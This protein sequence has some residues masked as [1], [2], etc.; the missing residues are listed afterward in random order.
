MIKKGVKLKN[1]VW[2]KP[3]IKK[4]KLLSTL[5]GLVSDTIKSNYISAFDGLVNAIDCFDFSKNNEQLGWILISKSI[6]NALLELIVENKQ[7]IEN[8]DFIVSEDFEKKLNSLLEN[9]NYYIN[10][11]FFINPKN[12]ALL[13]DAKPIISNFLSLFNFE[14][15]TIENILIR[16][17]SYFVFFLRREW[18]NNFDKYQVLISSTNTPF[19]RAYEKEIKWQS[20]KAK[21]NKLVNEPVFEESFS[22]KQVYIPLRAYYK[23]EKKQK[24]EEHSNHH[25]QLKKEYNKIVVDVE[26]EI[27]SWLNQN[28]PHNAIKVVR[29]GPG[30][31]KSSFLKILAAELSNKGNNVI[32]IPMHLFE[33]DGDFEQSVKNYAQKIGIEISSFVEK[34]KTILLFDGLDELSMQGKALSDAAKHFLEKLERKVTTINYEKTKIQVIVSGRDVIIQENKAL[35]KENQILRLLPFYIDEEEK[36]EYIDKRN[37]L[38]Y[39]QRDFWWQKYGVAKKLNFSKLPNDLNKIEL[40]KV[41]SQPLLNYLV[42]ITYD[43][44]GKNF[45]KNF[46]LNNL[47]KHFIKSVYERGYAGGKK[48]E[49]IRNFDCTRFEMILQ[50]IATSTWHGDGRKTTVAEI[51]NHFESAS[52]TKLLN[53]FII[54]AEKGVVSLLAA[55]YF[56]QAERDNEGFKTFEFTHKSFGE[57]LFATKAVKFIST[58]HRQFTEFETTFSTGWTIQDCFTKWI[59]L[60]G[61]KSIEDKDLLKFIENEF[62]LIKEANFE[63]LKNM[64]QTIIKLINYT[65]ANGIPMELL[66]QRSSFK[67]ETE[68]AKNTEKSLYIILSLIARQTDIVSEIKWKNVWA[69][70][71]LPSRIYSAKDSSEELYGQFFNHIRIKLGLIPHNRNF[72]TFNFERSVFCDTNFTET[73]FGASNLN[74]AWFGNISFDNSKFWNCSLEETDFEKCYFDTCEFDDSDFRESSFWGCQV[75]SSS[76]T[77]ISG[78]KAC[79][80]Y[81]TMWETTFEK[82]LLKYSSFKNTELGKCDFEDANLRGADFSNT[83]V[84]NSKFERANFIEASL[85]NAKLINCSFIDADL[86]DAN[87]TGANI[88]GANFTGA[89]LKGANF[90]NAINIDKAIG[91]NKAINL[92]QA[93]GLK[94]FV[95]PN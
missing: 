8:T 51:K 20:Y 85:L 16:L 66:K 32:L 87:L 77:C 84:V 91:L 50:E 39:D 52:L 49:V 69:F 88:E 40:D 23:T 75:Y 82:A 31:G 94:K 44:C 79:F 65:Q 30:Y 80:A 6:V 68:Q 93:I 28:N 56:K 22:L 34:G 17:N 67:L 90:T 14:R 25:L 95:K 42:A 41:T 26:A 70:E 18:Q 86:I 19:D 89:N 57:Y 63:K 7:E 15:S 35:F 83:K 46:N 48:L 33:M 76:I 72:D 55:F 74:R 92:E 61:I 71:D 62:I 11:D 1:G 9:K 29:G 13:E 53:E 78:I 59:E 10:N 5:L 58:L 12:F 45:F 60:F 64:Q 43:E 81:S 47:Y 36:K 27:T 3:K 38:Q 37:L 54:D 73:S 2:V 21:L 4:L 24:K